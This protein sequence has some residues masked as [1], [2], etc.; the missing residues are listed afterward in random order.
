ML[1]KDLGYVPLGITGLI[2]PSNSGK[3]KQYTGCPNGMNCTYLHEHDIEGCVDLQ[4]HDSRME[5]E[6]KMNTILGKVLQKLKIS[7][8][9]ESKAHEMLDDMVYEGTTEEGSGFGGDDEDY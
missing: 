8:K 6:S 3:P 2:C 1:S 4:N 7:R 5:V 9:V